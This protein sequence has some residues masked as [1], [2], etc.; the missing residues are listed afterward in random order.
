MT[1]T[2][3]NLSSTATIST[4]TDSTSLRNPALALDVSM[5]DTGVTSQNTELSSSNPSQYFC[6][7]QHCFGNVGSL[8]TSVVK[9]LDAAL[10]I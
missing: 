10:L 1:I 2:M 4:N 3:W 7:Y 9:A 6:Q 5:E 8:C